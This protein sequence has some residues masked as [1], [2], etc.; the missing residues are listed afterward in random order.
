MLIKKNESIKKI[1]DVKLKFVT[2]KSILSLHK[3]HNHVPVD[4]IVVVL[5]TG[6]SEDKISESTKTILISNGNVSFQQSIYNRHRIF[7]Q[8][9]LK[10][11]QAFKGIAFKSF[12]HDCNS[13]HGNNNI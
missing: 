1:P 7:W 11:L 9:C 12:R 10:A 5:A 13:Q 8:S 6:D 2:I 4:V 3:Q